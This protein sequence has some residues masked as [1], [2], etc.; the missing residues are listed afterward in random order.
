VRVI[1]ILPDSVSQSRH[2]LTASGL[3]VS[4]IRQSNIGSL[5]I[6]GTPTVLLVDSLGIVLRAWEGKLPPTKEQEVFEALGTV[7]KG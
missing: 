4:E 5:G 1:A 3:S 6:T 7:L 2:Y